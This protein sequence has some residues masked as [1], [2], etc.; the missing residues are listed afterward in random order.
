[1]NIDVYIN[2]KVNCREA[3]EFYS[4]VFGAERQQIMTYG[5]APA[6]PNFP[7]SEEIKNQV[8]HTSLNIKDRMLMFSDTPEFMP[9]I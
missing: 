6:D 4:E 2:F 7:L 3:V 5:E 1:M 9:F 8:M